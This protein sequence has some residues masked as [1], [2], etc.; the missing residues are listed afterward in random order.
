M[1]RIIF[2]FTLLFALGMTAQAQKK[3]V[4]KKNSKTTTKVIVPTPVKDAFSTEYAEVKDGKW[5]K[6]YA[7]NYVT[8]FSNADLAKQTNEY[9]ATG[10]LLK[11]KVVFDSASYPQQVTTALLQKYPTASIQNVTKVQMPGLAPYY[12]VGIVIAE[13]GRKRELFINDEG[14]ISL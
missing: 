4:V 2:G 11:S 7:G 12:K 3:S 13:T 10:Q 5:T 1:K 8:T 9:N 14:T 6:S